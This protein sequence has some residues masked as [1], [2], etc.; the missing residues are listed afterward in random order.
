MSCT[1][2]NLKKLMAILNEQASELFARLFIRPILLD[3][4]K[5]SAVYGYS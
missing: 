5:L 4:L 3:F 1:A 2:W